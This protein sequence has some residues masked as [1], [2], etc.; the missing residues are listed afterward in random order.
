M[1]DVLFRAPIICTLFVSYSAKAAARNVDF[2]GFQLAEQG[3]SVSQK[4]INKAIEIPRPRT[5]RQ[6]RS[7]LGF[8]GYLRRTIY[9]YS[10][11]TKPMV[12]LLTKGTKFKWEDSHELAFN[13]LKQNARAMGGMQLVNQANILLR[14]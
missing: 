5:V 3:L 10:N 2:V 14:Q 4:N 11:I 13:G 6:V 8:T 1:V 9:D 12:D 7:F